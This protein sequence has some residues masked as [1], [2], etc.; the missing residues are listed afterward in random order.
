MNIP[1]ELCILNIGQNY[2]V[3]GGSDVYLLALERLLSRFGH[4]VIP[5][6]ARH[7]QNLSSRWSSFFPPA[8]DF[9]HPGF[10]DL[11]RYVYSFPARQ[12]MARLLASRKVDLAHLHIYYGKLTSSILAPLR[13]RGIPIVQ[14]LHEYKTVCPTHQMLAHGEPCQ[15][16]GGHAFWQAVRKRCNRGSLARSLLSAVESYI[17]R[18][19]GS[20]SGIDHFIAVSDFVRSKVVE[21]GL[22]AEK[23]TTVHHFIDLTGTQPNRLPGEYFLY[24]GRIERAKGIFNLIEAFRPLRGMRLLL[25]GSGSALPEVERIIE[26]EGLDHILL[27][28]FRRGAELEALIRDSICTIT[29]SQCFETF[30]LTLIETFAHGRPVVASRIGGMTEVVADGVDGYLVPPGDAEALRE[31]LLWLAA[32]RH[33]ATEMGMAGRRKVEE[34][35]NPESHYRLI[36]EVYRKVLGR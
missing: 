26:R 29:P 32:H 14:T 8:A 3:V 6:A 5:F 25:V 31:R 34:R 19:C 17:S 9:D 16:C 10:R 27:L 4:E 2:R 33:E 24:F 35:F 13:S 20:I 28:G 12:A 11:C 15:A 1:T 18:G 36:R 30:G 22:P 23:V 7:P 21:L